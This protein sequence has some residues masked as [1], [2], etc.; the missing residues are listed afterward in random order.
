MHKFIIFTVS[1]VKDDSRKDFYYL[2]NLYVGSKLAT[3]NHKR[4]VYLVSTT[5][6]HEGS[7]GWGGNKIRVMV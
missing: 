1:S 5:R 2:W 6:G 7:E 4:G 3:L